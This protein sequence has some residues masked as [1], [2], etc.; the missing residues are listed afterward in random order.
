MFLVMINAK[1]AFSL[2]TVTK[3]KEKEIYAELV[4]F[5][6]QILMELPTIN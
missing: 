3:T 1:K 5:D 4:D 6:E 2:L